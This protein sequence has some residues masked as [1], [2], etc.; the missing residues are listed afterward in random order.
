MFNFIIRT[1]YILFWVLLICYIGKAQEVKILEGKVISDDGDVEGVVIQNITSKSSTIT[2]NK[3]SF[4]I[5]VRKNDKLMFLA[6]H[7]KRKWLIMN[8]VL[9]NTSFITVP[10]EEFV[11]ELEEVVV[12]PYNLSGE[13]SQDLIGLK[14]EKNISAEALG[15]PNAD[16]RIISQSENKLYDADHGKFLY[17][18][19]VGFAINVNKI[20]NRL[21]GRTKMLKD[22]VQLDKEYKKVKEVE[23]MFIDSLLVYHMKI[24]KDKFYDFMYY[25]QMDSKFQNLIKVN[26]ELVL[27]EF[28]IG[29]SKTYR[30]N[31][32]MD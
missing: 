14:L 9:F 32:N 17:F 5:E 2:D 30:K 31:Y 13:L 26:D 7:F 12:K 1:R 28:L 24:P 10:L 29:K 23:E 18:Y 25:C 6:I 21:N 11:N 20:L 8:N 15:L 4:S 3:G 19:G 27:W 16:I 22:R